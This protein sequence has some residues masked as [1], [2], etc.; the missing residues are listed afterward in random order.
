V[1]DLTKSLISNSSD[2]K[3]L[4]ISK[5]KKNLPEFK[6]TLSEKQNNLVHTHVNFC[7]KTLKQYPDI[8]YVFNN[9]NI[10]YYRITDKAS[11]PLCKLDHDDKKCIESRYETGE[12]EI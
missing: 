9:K 1:S 10:D 8:F 11:C 2:L 4:P 6:K 3:I 12:S 7:N 5:P